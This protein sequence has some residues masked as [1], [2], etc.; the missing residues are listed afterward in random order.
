MSAQAQ[1]Q[2]KKHSK[3]YIPLSRKCTKKFLKIA[4]INHKTKIATSS[5]QSKQKNKKQTNIFLITN[6]KIIFL[7]NMQRK[8]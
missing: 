3:L 4:L 6:K 2:T 7:F 5:L 8:K 1:I